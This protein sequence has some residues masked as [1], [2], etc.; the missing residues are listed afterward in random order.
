MTTAASQISPGRSRLNRRADLFPFGRRYT[1]GAPGSTG[2][3]INMHQDS[4]LWRM[5]WASR[6]QRRGRREDRGTEDCIPAGR[7][8]Y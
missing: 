6:G 4:N 7:R 5:T 2:R 1:R 8:G 3:G